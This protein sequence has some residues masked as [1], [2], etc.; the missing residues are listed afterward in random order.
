MVHNGIIENHQTLRDALHAKGRTFS[1]ET[2]TEII[3]HLVDEELKVDGK[4]PLRE[5]VRRALKQVQGAYAI[6]VLADPTPDQI[7]AAKNASPLVLG[8]GDGE[9]FVASD[10]PA[11][12][13]HTRKHAV[14]RGGRDRRG[15]ARPASRSSISTGS[16][17]ER[18]PKEITW[19]AVSA[20]KAG[21][22]HFMLKEIHEQARAVTDTL[23][24][25]LSVE[26]N[27]AF[28]DG[29]RARRRRTSRRSRSSP[30][31]RRGTR[32]SSASS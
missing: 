21:Y 25:R 27:D 3:A 26:H 18:A 19:S 20:E 22:K 11:I 24:G 29:H 8:L 2:D 23:R 15:D 6:V 28:L 16:K 30:A 14:P 32:R 9:N 10:V 12:L 31:A 5:A 7:V 13:T 1:S 4:V 17:V